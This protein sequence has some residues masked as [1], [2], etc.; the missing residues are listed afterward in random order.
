MKGL[1]FILSLTLLFYSCSESGTK[2]TESKVLSIGDSLKCTAEDTAS[3]PDHSKPVFVEGDYQFMY[4]EQVTEEVAY[5]GKRSIKLDPQH[6]FGMEVTIPGVQPDDVFLLTVMRKGTAGNFAMKCPTLT[7]QYFKFGGEIV[8]T[9]DDGWQQMVFYV[10]APPH[11]KGSEV[12][13]YL[14]YFEKG[15]VYFDDFTIKRVSFMKYPEYDSEKA[16]DIFLKEDALYELSKYRK[17]SFMSDL[18]PKDVKKYVKGIVSYDKD[19]AKGKLRLKGEWLDHLSGDKWSFR[20]KVKGNGVLGMDK[21]SLHTPV[22]RNFLKEYVAH[23]AFMDEG[24]LASKYDFLPVRLNG[25]S[26]GI[27]AIEE[28]FDPEFSERNNRSGVVLRWDEEGFWLA[29]KMSKNGQ[30]AFQHPM[31]RASFVSSFSFDDILD[32]PKLYNYYKKGSKLLYDFRDDRIGVE[33]AFC[34][35]Q[36]AKYMALVDLFGTY[37]G[38]TWH[39][40][41]YFYNADSAK[42]EPILFDGYSDGDRTHFNWLGRDFMGDLRADKYTGSYNDYQTTKIFNNQD[43][44]AKYKRYVERYG[45]ADYISELLQRYKSEIEK[46]E[47][48]IQREFTQYKYDSKLLEDRSARLKRLLSNTESVFNSFSLPKRNFRTINCNFPVVP[49]Y[50]V[51]AYTQDNNGLQKQLRLLNNYCKEMEVYV[52][53]KWVK[54]EPQGGEATVIADSKE[55]NLQMRVVNTSKIYN[56]EIL[57]YPRE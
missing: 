36:L 5:S 37:H 51:H 3:V 39:N 46:Y 24:L 29:Q 33:D 7:E 41:R 43:F 22:A 19:T 2:D 31:F 18:I 28:Y 54:L 32:D 16:I 13:F 45:S 49:I 57:P 26:L 55:E 25:R 27:Y 8:G 17:V 14:Q 48:L 15:V 20:V 44:R 12:K 23:K 40:I 9:T 50:S 6:R 52:G 30:N 10:K 35:D 1:F 4:G 56:L 21:F 34:L 53:D 47:Q 38:A 11:L 42:L